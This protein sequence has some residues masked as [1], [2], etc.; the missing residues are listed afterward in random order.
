MPPQVLITGIAGQDG[1]YLAEL[2]LEKG[3]EVHGLVRPPI[4]PDRLWRIGHILNRLHLHEGDI[5]SEKTVDDL[6]KKIAPQEIYHLAAVSVSKI[7]FDTEKD[8][9]ES[10]FNSVLYFLRAIKKHSP[11]SRFFLAASAIMYGNNSLLPQKEDTPFNPATPYAIAKTAAFYL[12]RMYR[13]AYG[14]FAVSGILF[15]HESP[16]RGSEFVTRKITQALARIKLGRQKEL[17]LGNLDSERDWAFAGDYVKAMWLMLQTRNPDDYVI[18]K[19]E[20]HSVR[21]FLEKA[22]GFLGLDYHDYVKSDPSLSG[23]GPNVLLSDPAKI[24]RELGWQAETSFDDLVK[25]M[26]ESDLERAEKE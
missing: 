25:K 1:S 12:V 13:L 3:Y 11:P 22:F 19:G 18:G 23:V 7:D 10:N 6:V 14:L 24:Y 9:F 17:V 4:S 16:R 15:G 5:R 21:E 20:K 26:V 8:V 2:L